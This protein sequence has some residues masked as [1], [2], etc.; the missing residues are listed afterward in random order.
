[1]GRGK[2]VLSLESDVFLFS[3]YHCE[4]INFSFSKVKKFFL[5]SSH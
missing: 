3:S 1:M 4:Q 2:T 5:D